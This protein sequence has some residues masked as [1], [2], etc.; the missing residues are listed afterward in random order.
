MKKSKENSE[1]YTW[2]NNC[3]AWHLVNNKDLSVIQETMP[4]GT[5]EKMHKHSH[6]QQFFFILSGQA[7]FIINNQEYYISEQQ[8]IHINH[9]VAHQI[10][11]ESQ[12]NLEFIVISQ[13]HAHGDRE[14]LS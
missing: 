14:D 9:N 6:S 7:T 12:E 2:G 4:P 3:F 10:S 13:P 11:N 5:K 8:G 1:K